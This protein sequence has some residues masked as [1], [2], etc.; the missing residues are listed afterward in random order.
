MADHIFQKAGESTWYVRLD[1]PKD[2]RKALGNRRVL[3]QSLKTGMRS[4]AMVNRLPILAQWKADIEA[5]RSTRKVHR[6]GW[7]D[8]VHAKAAEHRQRADTALI[9]GIRNPP[10]GSSSPTIETV[11][12]RIAQLAADQAALIAQVRAM[13]TETGIIGLAER[14]EA[15]FN[16]E[17]TNMTDGVQAADEITQH[18]ISELSRVRYDLSSSEMTEAKSIIINPKT[19]KPRS[20]IT[21]SMIDAW[22]NSLVSQIA[23]EKTRNSHRGRIEKISAYLNTEG[24]PLTFD[25]I[26]NFL[27]V[28][29]GARQTLANYLW[30]G[31]DFWRWAIKYNAQFREQFATQRC[32]FDDHTLPRAGKAAGES[33]IAFTRVEVENLYKLAREDGK[34]DLASLIVVG[35]YTGARLEEIGRLKSDD[36]INDSSGE[37]IGF[38]I[39][40]AKTSAG[41]RDVPIHSSLIPLYKK[42]SSQASANDGHLFKG[43]KNKYGNRLDGLSKQFGRLKKKANFSDLHV[44][45]SIRKT[46]TTELHQAG[47][48]L[49]VLPYLLGHENTSFT[50]STYSG[51]CSF[52]QK[53]EAIQK[54]TYDFDI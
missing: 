48:G 44:F 4:E 18:Y 6:D 41:V 1:V 27:T 13:E 51:G 43:G 40:Q 42:L 20:P 14:M 33:Y 45:H 39:N 19:Y 16:S 47:V 53:L 31:R 24:A 8:K 25:T 35:A 22:A 29:S 50:L 34:D 12:E 21:P 54:L 46:V 32:P 7:Q 52:E 5:A 49:E 30:S 28:Q 15:H 10:K 11:T 36:T 3:I 38:R 23:S 26:H 9:E 37:P 2:V 17:P